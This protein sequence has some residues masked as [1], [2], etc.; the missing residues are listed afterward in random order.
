MAIVPPHLDEV[1]QEVAR[2]L[3]SAL[4]NNDAAAII[5]ALEV[6]ASQPDPEKPVSGHDPGLWPYRLVLSGAIEQQNIQLVSYVLSHGIRIEVYAIHRALDLE[7][8][9]IFQ[10]FL[11]NGW[12]INEPLGE[13][14]PPALAYVLKN[15][16]LTT[17]FLTHGASPNASAPRLYRT[18]IMFA[19]SYAPLPI[20]RLLYTHGANTLNVLHTAAESPAPDRLAVIEYLLDE[21]GAEIN[22]VKWRHDPQSYADFEMLE[23]GTALHYAAKNGYADRVEMLLQRGARAEICDSTGKTALELARAYGMEGTMRVL[24]GVTAERSG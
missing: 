5:Q 19:A 14:S 16:P 3:E 11:D 1:E 12:D 8:I 9:P 10:T 24:E 2:E 21:P 22:A 13:T 4:D 23:L 6:W 18:P 20:I 7:S 15:E 17:W